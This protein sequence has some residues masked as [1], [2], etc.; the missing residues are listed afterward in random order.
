MPASVPPS[1]GIGATIL[2]VFRRNL[3]PG[4]ILNAIVI[5]LVGSYYLSP[6]V[7]GLWQTIGAFR[8]H[9]SYIFSAVSTI[10]VAALLPTLI[11]A[12][13]GTL[14]AEN[15]WRRL[16]ALILFWGYRGVEIDLMYRLQAHFFGTG[17]DWRTLTIKVSMDQFIYSLFWAVPT[18]LLVL[19]WVEMGCSW[20]RTRPTLTREFWTRT[21]PTVLFTNW[22]V[23]I[24]T[25]ALVYS[26]PLPL[27]FPLFAV[28]MCFFVLIVTLL[29]RE[30]PLPSAVAP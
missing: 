16:G 30:K 14:P 13:M 2:A 19:R 15:R 24:P 10:L 28:V 25:V 22:L 20:Q 3:V 17:N 23:W 27:Q 26:L 29:A 7:A 12:L 8:D 4:L 11:Q 18:Y 6:S 1:P 21:Y 9:W 5:L